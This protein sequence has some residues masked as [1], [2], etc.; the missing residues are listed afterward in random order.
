METLIIIS[1]PQFLILL[2][3][4]SKSI[5]YMKNH[6]DITTTERFYRFCF[7]NYMFAAFIKFVMIMLIG[8]P[9]NSDGT[10][11]KDSINKLVV[12]GLYILEIIFTIWVILPIINRHIWQEKK[13]ERVKIKEQLKH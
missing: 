12:Q 9:F 6:L 4:A 3:L 7:T 10:I 5:S 13:K 11:A 8:T 1:I 2:L